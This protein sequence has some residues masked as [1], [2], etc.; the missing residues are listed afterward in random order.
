[1][2]RFC[3]PPTQNHGHPTGFPKLEV[4]EP[5][6]RVPAQSYEYKVHTCKNVKHYTVS[7]KVPTFELSVT[8]SNLNQFSHCWKAYETH[9]T[10][11]YACCYTTLGNIFS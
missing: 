10:L 8:L 1:M 9:T 2:F 11:P 6:L 4:L 5:P 7:Q 3:G